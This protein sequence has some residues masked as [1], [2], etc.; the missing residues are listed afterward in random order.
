M[1]PPLVR[2]VLQAQKVA[3]GSAKS[4]IEESTSAMESPRYDN[5][6]VRPQLSQGIGGSPSAD[7]RRII[8]RKLPTTLDPNRSTDY[9]ICSYLAENYKDGIV[10]LQLL[11]I[12][13]N[14]YDEQRDHLLP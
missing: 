11:A 6:L 13:G 5:L 7:G 9:G 12:S 1:I 8:L 2:P 4:D 10:R 14:S 3:I